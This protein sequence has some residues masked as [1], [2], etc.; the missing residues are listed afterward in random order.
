MNILSQEE[1][2]SVTSISSSAE[3]LDGFLTPSAISV[4]KQLNE[5]IQVNIW[6]NID[7]FVKLYKDIIENFVAEVANF[8]YIILFK[9]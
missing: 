1:K 7:L 4:P 9:Y 2:E 8:V 6:R 3:S 5:Q